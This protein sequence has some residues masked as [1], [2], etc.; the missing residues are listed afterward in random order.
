[1]KRRQLTGGIMAA[2]VIAVTSWAATPTEMSVQIRNAQLRSTPSYLGAVAG[3][4]AYAER[5]AI[6]TTQGDWIQVR[7]AKATGWI[8]KSALSPKRISQQAGTGDVGTVASGEEMSL[9]GKGFNAQV[10]SEFKAK[11]AKIDFSAIDRMEQIKIPADD[12]R[13]F[14]IE[15]KLTA[16]GGAR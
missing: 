8:H 1:M 13:K 3:S 9:A 6:L 2:A 12:I 7:T 16:A 11:N 10:E 5:V 4:A 15:G 14:L